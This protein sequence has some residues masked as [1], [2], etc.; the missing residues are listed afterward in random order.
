MDYIYCVVGGLVV[1]GGLGFWFK[2]W[3]VSKAQLAA[4]L[5]DRA[6]ARVDSAARK[7]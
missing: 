7:L 6:A 1:G 3:L 2:G 4:V 5:A